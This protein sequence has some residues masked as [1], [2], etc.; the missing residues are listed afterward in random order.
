MRQ[1]AF[2]IPKRG[3]GLRREKL[4]QAPPGLTYSQETGRSRIQTFLEEKELQRT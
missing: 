4:L 3:G 2:W 1:Q